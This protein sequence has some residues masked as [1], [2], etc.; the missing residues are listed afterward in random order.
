MSLVQRFSYSPSLALRLFLNY[1]FTIYI[2]LIMICHFIDYAQ[3]LL[4]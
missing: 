3:I 2:M 4:E 1:L